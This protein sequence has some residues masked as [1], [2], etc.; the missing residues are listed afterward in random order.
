[1][2]AADGGHSRVA[3]ILLRKGAVVTAVGDRGV[4]ALHISARRGHLTMTN[5]LVKA[6]ADLEAEDFQGCTPL[7]LAAQLG[8]SRVMEALVAAGANVDH[9]L[10]DGATPIF[11][12]AESAQLGAVKIL[13]EA[14]ADPQLKTEGGCTPLEVAVEKGHADIVHELVTTTKTDG[15]GGSTRGAFALH[16]ATQGGHVAIMEILYTAGAKRRGWRSPLCRC[17][18]RRRASPKLLAAATGCVRD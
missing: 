6:G 10:H 17:V 5:L 3:K 14:K 13:L 15:C 1:M 11:L 12:A 2:F 4:T 16:L 8:K 9:P 18:V 7:H